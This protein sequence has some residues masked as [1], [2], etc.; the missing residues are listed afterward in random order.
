M[1]NHKNQSS[2]A[3]PK[4][5]GSRSMYDVPVSSPRRSN[6]AVTGP[7]S[8]SLTSRSKSF[9]ILQRNSPKPP[10]RRSGGPPA[11]PGRESSFETK[12]ASRKSL[13][14]PETMYVVEPDTPKSRKSSRASTGLL[15]RLSWLKKDNPPECNTNRSRSTS[16]TNFDMD[17]TMSV[18]EVSAGL[19]SGRQTKPLWQIARD[20]KSGTHSFPRVVPGHCYAELNASS[21]AESFPA[22]LLNDIGLGC[23]I[24][25]CS[26]NFAMENILFYEAAAAVLEQPTAES[27][28]ALQNQYLDDSARYNVNIGGDLRKALRD[29]ISRMHVLGGI[30]TKELLRW[31]EAARDEI[32]LVMERDL[33]H[34]FLSSPQDSEVWRKECEKACEKLSGFAVPAPAFRAPSS[35]KLELDDSSSESDGEED[36]TVPEPRKLLKSESMSERNNNN[37]NK[38][39]ALEI[40]ALGGGAGLY[41]PTSTQRDLSQ[42]SIDARSVKREKEALIVA[43]LM[44][45][46]KTQP[47]LPPDEAPTAKAS[48]RV[49]RKSTSVLLDSHRVS[50]EEERRETVRMSRRLSAEVEATAI[51]RLEARDPVLQNNDNLRM[52]ILRKSLRE[53][54]MAPMDDIKHLLRENGHFVPAVE[55]LHEAARASNLS[56]SNP[57]NEHSPKDGSSP[58]SC[59]PSVTSSDFDLDSILHDENKR[60]E[61]VEQEQQ[62][63][64]P[65]AND[66][67][68][69]SLANVIQRAKRESRNLSSGIDVGAARL[70]P[71]SG[72]QNGDEFSEVVNKLKRA[73]GQQQ[74]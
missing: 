74:K 29:Q 12:S 70:I 11:K 65:V 9:A 39:P 55:A 2:S 42:R 46:M 20:M 13:G 38:L 24:R 53:I 14:L 56:P 6:T 59:D 62:P 40:R 17:A 61:Q 68:K 45:R 47:P 27:F 33:L 30:V 72:P 32:Y 19:L 58:G 35:N 73:L 22:L 1:S 67:A 54:Q 34:R 16:S 51:E 7:D 21:L 63:S 10:A 3:T 44:P 64:A 4:S 37:N 48:A 41:A 66:A 23:F 36:S 8:V 60:P 18:D 5:L 57:N 28:R 71:G 50:F 52:L 25:F 31:L 43:R 15:A 69:R 49:S 26:N